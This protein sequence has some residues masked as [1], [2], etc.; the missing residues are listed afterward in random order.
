M[1]STRQVVATPRR[2][3]SSSLSMAFLVALLVNTSYPSAVV[4]FQPLL[5]ATPTR[6]RVSFVH[7][8]TTT[9]LA[10]SYYKDDDEDDDDDEED[11]IDLNSLGDWRTFRKNLASTGITTPQQ[12]QQQSQ[13]QGGDTSPPPKEDVEQ[14]RVSVSKENEKLLQSQNKE[15]AQ[16]YMTGVWAHKTSVPEVGGL[17]V[18]LPLE[19]EIM[20]NYRHSV[21]GQKLRQS[22]D[23]PEEDTPINIQKKYS[24]SAF[25]EEDDTI[26][27]SLDNS[28]DTPPHNTN[29]QEMASAKTV[30]WYRAA[31]QLVEDEMLSIAA[32]AEDG[33]IDATTL[34]PEAAEM[35]S[36]YLDNQETWQEVNLVLE[37]K[38]DTGEATAVVINRPMA[39]KLTENLARLVLFGAY[40]ADNRQVTD[41]QDLIRFLLAFGDTCGVYVGGPH[42]QE[43]PAILIHGIRDLPGATEI[44]PG[45][46]IYRGGLEAAID[47]VLAGTYDP[48]DFRFFIGRHMYTDNELDVAVHLGKYQPIACARSVALKQCIS[49]PKPLWHEVLEL[50]GGDL[51][52]VSALELLK[53]DDIKFEV[54]DDDDIPNELDELDRLDDDDDD[55]FYLD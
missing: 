39:L 47:G 11:E 35:L 17:I 23:L 19:I 3:W 13:Q 43:Q 49:L 46:N 26:Q 52:D 2:P 8:T 42:H 12:Q 15:L 51:N 29:N 53:R 24:S 54:I 33:Q 45:A 27:D 20:R 25:Y 41:E 5:P 55:D 37:S 40:M 34:Q 44:S 16:E 28:N 21:I 36:L 7:P 14:T 31:K 9:T 10:S 48:L 30:L 6:R 22:L 38:S 32:E 4:A 1:S 18:R 50:C